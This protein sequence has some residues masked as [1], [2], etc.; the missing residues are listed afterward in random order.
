MGSKT[1]ERLASIED[2][3]MKL[4]AL[5]GESLRSA[6][7]KVRVA[8]L[9]RQTSQSLL[10]LREAQEEAELAQDRAQRAETDLELERGK[11]QRLKRRVA[12]LSEGNLAE[13]YYQQLIDQY[14]PPGRD[15]A[16]TLKIAAHVVSER[17][18]LPA[19]QLSVRTKKREVVQARWLLWYILR[20]TTSASLPDIGGITGHFDHS[21]VVHGLK[22]IEQI[23]SADPLAYHW[24]E[25]LIR[26]LNAGANSDEEPG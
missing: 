5:V 24:V 14:G 19:E 6:K 9:E 25:D 16:E 1:D 20:Q 15:L 8:D 23:R 12:A 3:L 4:R 17:L 11:T 2:E 21:T 13:S 10:R 26:Q 7:I 22:R 18:A